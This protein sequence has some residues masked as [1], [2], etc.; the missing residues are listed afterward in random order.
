MKILGDQQELLDFKR[1]L[2]NHDITYI[3]Y[4]FHAS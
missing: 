3:C 4:L 2:Q 1:V